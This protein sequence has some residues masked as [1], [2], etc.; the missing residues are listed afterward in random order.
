M[1][2]LG[3]VGSAGTGCAADI[4]S[5][6]IDVCG[7]RGV[8]VWTGEGIGPAFA[9]VDRG[10]GCIGCCKFSFLFS[11]VGSCIYSSYA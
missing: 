10:V 8:G 1:P 2:V 6:Y 3:S 7:V 5:V 9:S 11:S 4:G